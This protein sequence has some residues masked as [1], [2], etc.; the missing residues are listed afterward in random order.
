M[1][2][3]T[4]IVIIILIL[5]IA[6]TGLLYFFGGFQSDVDV[7]NNNNATTIID[8]NAGL[9]DSDTN[10]SHENK[11]NNNAASS[12]YRIM[13]DY[14]G[15][16]T[17]GYGSANQ[18]DDVTTAGHQEYDL[19]ETTYVDVGAKKSDGGSGEL[20]LAIYKGDKLV[21]EKTTTSPYGEVIINYKE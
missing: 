20:R 6:V 5:A 3:Y 8:D 11:D 2:I 16:Y 1:K 18:H 9:N 21:E 14:N 13:I 7:D 4:K 15:E 12:G 19:G 17:A 10:K